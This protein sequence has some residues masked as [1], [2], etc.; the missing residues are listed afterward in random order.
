MKNRKGA[1]L[2]P[3]VLQYYCMVFS[4]LLSRRGAC[5]T[6]SRSTSSL[7]LQQQPRR[8]APRHN[9]FILKELGDLL[10]AGVLVSATALWCSPFEVAIEKDG[11]PRLCIVYRFL[12]QV[13]EANRCHLLV[14]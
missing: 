8:V 9:S 5:E 12:N 11:T 10:D 14:F 4:E 2:H 1:F 7:R 6:L 3:E 13:M